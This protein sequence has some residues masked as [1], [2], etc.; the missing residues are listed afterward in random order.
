MSNR[1]KLPAATPAFKIEND[2]VLIDPD[3]DVDGQLTRRI[4]R[5]ILVENRHDEQASVHATIMHQRRGSKNTPWYDADSFDLRTLKGGEEVRIELTAGQTRS[6]FESLRGLYAKRIGSRPPE[7]EQDYVLVPEDDHI[8][9][10]NDAKAV[11]MRYS[12]LAGEKIW[13]YLDELHPDLFDTLAIKK[14]HQQKCAAVDEFENHLRLNDWTEDDWG[15]FF[16]KNLWIF[17]HNL[18]YHFLTPLA[19]ESHMG[20]TDYDGQGANRLDFNLATDAPNRFSVLVDIKRPSSKLLYEKP[21]RSTIYRAG[22][23]LS[24]GVAQLQAY[25]RL[26]AVEGSKQEK[27]ARKL[28]E[29]GIYVYEPKGILVVGSLAQLGND[30]DKISSFELF[31]RNLHNP[32]VITYDELFRRAEKSLDVG[33]SELAAD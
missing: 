6:L 32:E 9:L 27:N 4:L 11:L 19:I 12:E 7:E 5:P 29:Q 31:R 25:C 33:Q 18:T 30:M 2:V 23:E 24:G 16:E 14:H 22:K 1:F 21:Y 26:W 17:G 8:E 20:G 15:P 10:S 28:A 3:D 13:E